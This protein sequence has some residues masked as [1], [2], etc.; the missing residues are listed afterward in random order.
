MSKLYIMLQRTYYKDI[1]G[2]ARFCK[3][4]VDMLGICGVDTDLINFGMD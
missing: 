3:F 4:I 1:N 2:G